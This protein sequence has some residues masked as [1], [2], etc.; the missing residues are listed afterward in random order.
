LL[1]KKDEVETNEVDLNDIISETMEIVGAEAVKN[2]VDLAAYKPNGALPVRLSKPSAEEFGL[3]IVLEAVRCFN[4]RCPY[5]KL[6]KCQA[7]L[8]V[9]L[10]S[11]H[12]DAYGSPL[13]N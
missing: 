8:M 10:G 13:G 11:A 1:K 7:L 12:R 3:K 5:Q 4:L 6:R 2:G 9:R